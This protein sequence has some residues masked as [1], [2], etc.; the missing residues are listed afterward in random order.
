MWQAVFENAEIFFFE[1]WD[2]ITMLGGGNNIE[3]HDGDF[4]GDSDTGFRRRGLL[5]GRPL[6]LL[7]RG[8]GLRWR[9]GLWTFRRLRQ[10][11]GTEQSRSGRSYESTSD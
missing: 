7:R 6:L 4:D 5:L 2:E 11:D 8:I 10:S 1:A 9:T 3:S